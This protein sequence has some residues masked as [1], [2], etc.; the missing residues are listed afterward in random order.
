MC[1]LS[2]KSVIHITIEKGNGAQLFEEMQIKQTFI[3]VAE[4]VHTTFIHKSHI[5]TA[6]KSILPYTIFNSKYLGIYYHHI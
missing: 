3:L 1:I 2:N 4:I 6:F 5:Y